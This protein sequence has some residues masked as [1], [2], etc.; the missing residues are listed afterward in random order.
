MLIL[1]VHQ[2]AVLAVL[3]FERV[4]CHLFSPQVGVVLHASANRPS[5]IFEEAIRLCGALHGT[6]GMLVK[7]AVGDGIPGAA[8][9]RGLRSPLLRSNVG[10]VATVAA[11]ALSDR[12]GPSLAPFAV[13]HELEL[14][15]GA[16]NQATLFGCNRP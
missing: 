12:T 3:V 11:T 9:G 6:R 5:S 10:R 15:E 2:D 4:G 16:I 7:V 1:V 14:T 8:D 13:P